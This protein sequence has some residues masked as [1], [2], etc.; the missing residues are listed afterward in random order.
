MPEGWGNLSVSLIWVFWK[1]GN[2]DKDSQ[3]PPLPEPTSLM[4]LPFLEAAS[5][6]FAAMGS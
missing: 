6:I 5:L 4:E 2:F 1:I 3:G